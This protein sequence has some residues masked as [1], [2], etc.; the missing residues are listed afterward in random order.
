MKYAVM[1]AL[2][3]L[4]DGTDARKLGRDFP[5]DSLWALDFA[6]SAADVESVVDIAATATKRAARNLG[7]QTDET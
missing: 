5:A 1:T 6:D 4:D 2:V 3:P 7:N